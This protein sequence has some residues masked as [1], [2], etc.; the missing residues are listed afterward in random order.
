[1]PSGCLA[2]LLVAGQLVLESPGEGEAGVW[3]EPAGR[4][5]GGCLA[6]RRVW[7]ASDADSLRSGHGVADLE[8]CD[9]CGAI[10]EIHR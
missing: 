6:G 9:G 5:D 10:V 4:L 2:A 7:H 1:M 3:H 8:L